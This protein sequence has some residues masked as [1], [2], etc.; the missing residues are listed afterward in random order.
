MRAV[1]SDPR[2]SRCASVPEPLLD[3][4]RRGRQARDSRRKRRASGIRLP[5]VRTDALAGSPSYACCFVP[6]VR[7]LRPA[8]RHSGIQPRMNQGRRNF[9]SIVPAYNEEARLG[10]TLSRIR[11]LFRRDQHAANT[12]EIIVVDDGSTDGTGGHPGSGPNGTPNQLRLFSTPRN[13]GK[14][15]SV[16][17]GT[18]L[19]RAAISRFSPMPIRPRPSRNP[20]TLRRY[21]GGSGYC[22]RLTVPI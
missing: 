1:R 21:R 16:R 2:D 9:R 10:R 6:L 12:L 20:K 7:T 5:L 13:G 4:F 8:S 14:G 17:R 18:C 11:E 22:D 19:K 3:Q 15:F